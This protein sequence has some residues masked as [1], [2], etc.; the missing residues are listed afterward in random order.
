[1][2]RWP[3]NLIRTHLETG[4]QILLAQWAVLAPF[5]IT[6]NNKERSYDEPPPLHSSP[7]LF[8][9]AYRLVLLR[10]QRL[11]LSRLVV[12][13]GTETFSHGLPE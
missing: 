6:Q 2:Y 9:L 3:P 8:P 13:L 1:M 5:Y 4:P 11:I 12:L 7:M 10:H